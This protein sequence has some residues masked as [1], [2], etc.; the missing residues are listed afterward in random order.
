MPITAVADR[1]R[2]M[3]LKDEPISV[4]SP[5]TDDD[6]T[7]M[8][9]NVH[10]IEPSISK[11]DLSADAFMKEFVKSHCHSSH[12]VFQVKK[13]LNPSCY[14]C[15]EHPVVMDSE[16]FSSVSFL[17]LPLLDS[18]KEHFF[19]FSEVYGKPL[20]DKDRP[21]RGL[22][23][24]SEAKEFDKNNK[25]LLINS[26]VRCVITCQECRKSRCIFAAK[27]LDLTAKKKIDDIDSLKVYTCGSFLFPQT[28]SYSSTVVRL[29][30]TCQD[31]IEVQY[32]SSTIV[33]FPQVC[34]HCGAP[35]EMMMKLWN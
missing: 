27:K 9:E 35:E 12:Y 5:A 20:S 17:P 19:P 10:F 22:Y 1:F 18:T 31:P 21:S 13:C 8:I 7:D 15:C 29:S 34:Y 24:N 30:L 25:A 26:K 2:A 16:I 11:E 23:I 3:K 28:S 14:Y 33:A 6:I 32:Y 4:N